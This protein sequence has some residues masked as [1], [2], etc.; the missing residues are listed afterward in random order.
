[1]RRSFAAVIAAGVLLCAKGAFAHRID[2]YLQATLLSLETNRVNASMRL[3]PGMLVSASVIAAIDSNGDGAFSDSEQRAYAQRVLGDL[4][5]AVDGKNAQP[6]LDSWSFPDPAQMREGL[7]E[8]HIEYNI[9]YSADL[10]SSGPNRSLTVTNHHL[11]RSS[12]YLM[13]V[14][15]PQDPGI[16]ILA[17]KRNP[18]GSPKTGHRGSL[19]NRPTINR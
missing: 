12:V 6:V 4:S 11:N 17:Q 10:P 5:I 19:Q 2:E 8:I 16:R 13:N 7:G 18:R 14:L 15:V 3:I 1:M 9:E